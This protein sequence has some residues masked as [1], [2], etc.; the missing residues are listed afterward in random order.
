MLQFLF[1]DVSTSWRKCWVIVF[2]ALINLTFV[3][4][5]VLSVNDKAIKWV[6][7]VYCRSFNFLLY[8]FSAAPLFIWSLLLFF[9]THFAVGRIHN[10]MRV[11]CANVH[12]R[13]VIVRRRLSWETLAGFQG[14][15]CFFGFTDFDQRL[16]TGKM[17]SAIFFEFVIIYFAFTESSVLFECIF[18]IFA[19][20]I[21]VSVLHTA[22]REILFI[23]LITLL[24]T[25]VD[26]EILLLRNGLLWCTFTPWDLGVLPTIFGFVGAFSSG[27]SGICERLLCRVPL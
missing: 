4:K 8:N 11:V 15:I 5:F 22:S 14:G 2:L 23:Y 10:I 7:L 26:A 21:T 17:L 13:P 9:D 1:Q 25:P 20:L 18:N 27:Y 16:D 19:W 24:V 6:L 12:L 3:D